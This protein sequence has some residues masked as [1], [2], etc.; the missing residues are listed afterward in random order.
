MKNVSFPST[1]KFNFEQQYQ[2]ST[3]LE[4][5]ILSL[6]PRMGEQKRTY[7]LFEFFASQ[8]PVNHHRWKLT[9]KQPEK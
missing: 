2:N 5:D 3:K 6:M 4:L 7:I 1:L 8:P 9:L